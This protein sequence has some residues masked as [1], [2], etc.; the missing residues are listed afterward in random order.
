MWQSAPEAQVVTDSKVVILRGHRKHEKENDV[1][2]TVMTTR[3]HSL[4]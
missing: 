1:V 3:N 4:T 2:G